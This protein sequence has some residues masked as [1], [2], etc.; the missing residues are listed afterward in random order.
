M[1]ELYGNSL[2]ESLVVRDEE[3][4][5]RKR[6]MGEVTLEKENMLPKSL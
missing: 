2:G 1:G 6:R 5:M 4:E 3:T